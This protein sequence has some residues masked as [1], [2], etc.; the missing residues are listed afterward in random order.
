[1]TARES[2]AAVS[3]ALYEDGGAGFLHDEMA[4]ATLRDGIRYC[5]PTAFVLAHLVSA[6]WPMER[7][8]AETDPDGDCWFLWLAAGSVPEITAA[9]A[10]RRLTKWVAFERDHHPHLLPTR[11][12]LNGQQTEQQSGNGAPGEIPGGTAADERIPNEVHGAAAK[13]AGGAATGAVSAT[14]GHPDGCQSWSG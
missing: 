2:A 11:R 12:F 8:R 6:G 14:T 10:A 3:R 1:M 9:L 5:T 7:M 4:Y 13:G